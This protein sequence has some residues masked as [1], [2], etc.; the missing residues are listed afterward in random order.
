MKPAE[1]IPIT[2]GRLMVDVREARR[3]LFDSKASPHVILCRSNSDFIIGGWLG[4]VCG[5]EVKS[6]EALPLVIAHLKQD[7]RIIN[8]SATN[9]PYLPQAVANAYMEG[10]EINPDLGLHRHQLKSLVLYDTGTP[11]YDFSV[12]P[13]PLKPVFPWQLEAGQSRKA[14]FTPIQPTPPDLPASP[15]PNNKPYRR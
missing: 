5:V 11:R 15:I 4:F 12:T 9:D 1:Y 6:L 13:I 2:W 10:L 3:M 8:F 14:S 7:T